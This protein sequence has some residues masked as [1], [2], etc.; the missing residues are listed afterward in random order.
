MNNPEDNPMTDPKISFPW[1]LFICIS[2]LAAVVGC[3][4]LTQDNFDKIKTGMTY[5]EVTDIIG[6]P[7]SCDSMFTAKQCQWKS[8]DKIIDVKLLN[9]KVVIFSAQNL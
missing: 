1:I 9:D 7:T 3:G 4:K 8:G 2:L 5:E 6:D